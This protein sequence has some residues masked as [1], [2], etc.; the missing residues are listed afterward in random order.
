MPWN[1]TKTRI[2]IIVSAVVTAPLVYTAFEFIAAKLIVQI[3]YD[4]ICNSYKQ[5]D[6]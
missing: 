3:S 4:L 2:V 1:A 5:T 6:A